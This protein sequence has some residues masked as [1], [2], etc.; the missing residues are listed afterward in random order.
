MQSRLRFGRGDDTVIVF[1]PSHSR[2][3]A[4]LP[5]QDVWATEAFNLFGKLFGGA[6]GFPNLKGIWRD[7]ENGGE[8]LVDEPIMIQSLVKRADVE[9]PANILELAGFLKRMGKRTKQGAVA[10]IFNDAI[11]FISN[12]E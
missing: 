5:N 3:K 2:D 8:L 1:I 6:T 4:R 10:I 11:H 9:K 7:D 12:Y